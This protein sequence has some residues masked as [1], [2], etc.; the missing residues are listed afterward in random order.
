MKNGHRCT[1]R[2]ES[3]DTSQR[4]HDVMEQTSEATPLMVAGPQRKDQ[5]ASEQASLPADRHMGRTLV[6]PRTVSGI[7]T[8][9]GASKTWRGKGSEGCAVMSLASRLAKTLHDG[10]SRSN[11]ASNTVRD[12]TYAH[13]PP[14]PLQSN[15]IEACASTKGTKKPFQ[16]A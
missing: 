4:L 13:T 5:Q 12:P 15:Q 9:R 1:S 11:S 3:G 14:P 16:A 6:R 2:R 7:K 10:M 8:D